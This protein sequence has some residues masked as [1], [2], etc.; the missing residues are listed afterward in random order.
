MSSFPVKPDHFSPH[1]A[2]AG[3]EIRFYS[4]WQSRPLLHGAARLAVV[5]TN[6][7][8]R[9][10]SLDSASN[11]AERNRLD[12]GTDYTIPH[13]QVDRNGR[14]RKI[15]PTNRRGICN[16]TGASLEE[17]DGHEDVSWFSYAIETADT[18]TI[19]DPLISAFTAAQAETVATIIAYESVVHG[20][21]IVIPSTWYGTGVGSHTDPFPYPAWTTK[22]GKTCPGLSKK[23]QVR[24]LIIP[25]A[26]AIKGAWTVAPP[27]V[28]PPPVTPPPA[29]AP[30]PVTTTPAQPA[31]PPIQGD[32]DMILLLRYGGTPSANWGGWASLNGGATRTAVTGPQAAELFAKGAYDG[33]TFKRV[34]GWA[35]VSHTTSTDVLNDR[36]GS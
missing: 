2:P 32:D 17:Q 20:Y 36:L 12:D 22:R 3:V 31:L 26:Q 28:I 19:A 13:Y 14:A 25:R 15:L 34:T 1:G 30:A 9:E 27:V 11:W 29:P 24:D 16:S 35:Q 33:I 8:E 4:L 10:G 7:A 5:H 21:P 6:A 18:G 23:A